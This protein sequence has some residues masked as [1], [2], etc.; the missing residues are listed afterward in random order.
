[1]LARLFAV[2]DDV[3]AAILLLL[4]AGL[5]RLREDFFE[6]RVVDGFA[7]E[8]LLQDV[9]QRMRPRQAADMGGLDAVGVL[10]QRHNTLPVMVVLVQR[11]GTRAPFSAPAR[12]ILTHSRRN[13]R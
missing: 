7:A 4:H 2:G 1:M 11:T 5:D 3:D 10:L 8:F 9:E 13:E 6:L 12:S